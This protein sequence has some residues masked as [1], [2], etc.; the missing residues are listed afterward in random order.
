VS[1]HAEFDPTRPAVI[2]SGGVLGVA[3][4]LLDRVNAA[5]AALSAVAAG[6][7]GCVLTWEVIGRYFLKLPSDWQDELSIFLLVGATFMAAGWIQSKRGHVGIDAL[8]H[9]LP[10]WADRG[11]RIFADLASL[12]FCVFFCWKSWTLL[13]EAWEDG[14]TTSSSWNPPL[15]IPY[16]LMSVGMTLLVAQLVLQVLARGIVPESSPS[17]LPSPSPSGRGS[18]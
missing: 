4:S 6:L 14:Q 15:A 1:A 16:G 3:Q 18:G 17:S 2:P 12:A 5:A 10:E 9:I 7:A 8:S 13:A 11:R